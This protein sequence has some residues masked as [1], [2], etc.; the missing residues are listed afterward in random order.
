MAK[1]NT[2]S[3]LLDPQNSIPPVELPN[4]RPHERSGPVR[5]VV[6]IENGVIKIEVITLFCLGYLTPI[7]GHILYLQASALRQ[8]SVST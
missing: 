8:I 6:A 5:P 7:N 2:V 1:S 3:L 4:V